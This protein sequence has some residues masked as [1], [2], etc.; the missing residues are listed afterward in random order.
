MARDGGGAL[1]GF[2][3]IQ[4][5]TLGP[6]TATDETAAGQLLDVG[7]AGIDRSLKA[8]VLDNVGER[9]LLARGLART[10]PLPRL[11]L[12]PAVGKAASPRLLAH[13]SYALG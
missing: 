5:D 11:R 8:G 9:L 4:D 12:G 13:A 10:R 7:L 6:W 3:V 2:L 1:R